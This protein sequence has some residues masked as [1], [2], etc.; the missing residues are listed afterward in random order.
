MGVVPAW[1][2]H[3]LGAHLVSRVLLALAAERAPEAWLTVNTNNPAG[4]LYARLGFEHRG[5]RPGYDR[6]LKLVGAAVVLPW[7]RLLEDDL[8]VVRA[9]LGEPQPPVELQPR[10]LSGPALTRAGSPAS[11]A[12]T[13][14]CSIR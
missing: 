12:S 13:S 14:S 5:K 3:G 8:A 11:C 1:R 9:D 2:G 7:R 6:W 4:D 10:G